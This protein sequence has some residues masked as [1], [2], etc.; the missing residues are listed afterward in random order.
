MTTNAGNVA[1]TAN[2]F[3]VRELAPAVTSGGKPPHSTPWPHAPTHCLTETGIYMVTAGTYL[4]QRLFRDGT[5]L[6]MLHE[7]LLTIADKHSWRL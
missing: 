3:G 4:K 1:K 6:Q 7:A 2:E 5:P